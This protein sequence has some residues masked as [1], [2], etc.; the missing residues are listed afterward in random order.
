M[1]KRNVIVGVSL[2]LG[3]LYLGL[4]FMGDDQAQNRPIDLRSERLSVTQDTQ[5]PPKPERATPSANQERVNDATDTIVEELTLPETAWLSDPI[6][7]LSNALYDFIESEQVRYINTTDYPFDEEKERQLNALVQA[8]EMIMFDNT[9][10]DYL[11]SYGVSEAQVVSEYFGTASK[12]DVIV[13]TAVVLPEGGMHY[14]VLP[15]QRKSFDDDATL[16]SDVK[17]A[18]TLLKDQKFDLVKPRPT[19]AGSSDSAS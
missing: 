14:L 17:Q 5:Q 1:T 7:Q 9:D 16:I 18:V 6:N 13:A 2:A 12:G 4:N 10:P 19:E 11:D 15:L 3:A 8:G